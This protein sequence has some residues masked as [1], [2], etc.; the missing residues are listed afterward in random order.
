LGNEDSGSILAELSQEDIK[1]VYTVIYFSKNMTDNLDGE[2]NR[3][4]HELG[5]DNFPFALLEELA[6]RADSEWDDPQIEEAK[7]LRIETLL[8]FIP[9]FTNET[10][11]SYIEQFNTNIGYSLR[12]LEFT[13][14]QN[15]RDSLLVVDEK[16]KLRE[17]AVNKDNARQ[18]L[19]ELK[20]V[21]LQLRGNSYHLRQEILHRSQGDIRTWE[22]YTYQPYVDR[23]EVQAYLRI[24]Q[25]WLPERRILHR[26]IVREQR[27]ASDSLSKRF[28]ALGRQPTIY[29]LRGNTA[30]GKMTTMRTHERLKPA[31]DPQTGEPSGVINPDLYKT[32]LRQFERREGELMLSHQ[33]VHY[34]GVAI[35]ETLE[36]LLMRSDL[37]V[38]IDRRLAEDR[39]VDKYIENAKTYGKKL[40][41]IDIDAPLE[42]SLSSV[43][44]RGPEDEDPR[45]RF[46]IISEGYINIRGFREA[47]IRRAE[48]VSSTE[49]YPE[50]SYYVLFCR[51]ENHILEIAEVLHG[52]LTVKDQTL[53]DLAIDKDNLSIV[54]VDRV[55]AIN[56]S[57]YYI[58]KTLHKFNDRDFKQKLRK[59]LSLHKG[60]MLDRA[61]DDNA[62]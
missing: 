35:G 27:Q 45:T 59:S 1:A 19:L 51:D 29:C 32:I 43:L 62:L 53:F 30:A 16:G 26:E 48:S 50:I 13:L 60:K 10:A 3:T 8:Q 21:D 54:E 55:K 24:R 47:I 25:N 9:Q 23:D 22:A 17:I 12:G 34:E 58:R 31:I 11:Q 38:I 39:E 49:R 61:I 46:E 18:T 52:E 41:I 4:S 28:E 57:D 56:I 37:T 44:T 6:I 5:I 7:R 14:L 2:N 40:E 33:Q 36:D 20:Q 15:H 42:L